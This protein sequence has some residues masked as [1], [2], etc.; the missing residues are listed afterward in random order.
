MQTFWTEAGGVPQ[1]INIIESAQNK[2]VCTPLPVTDAVM[3]A[4]T[5]R[6]ILAS[7]EYPN[8]MREWQKLTPADQ[9]W[10]KW[11]TKFLLAYTA[12]ELSDKARDA[13]GQPLGGQAIA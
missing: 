11:K 2:S 6:A 5:F 1:Y 10:D 12:K 9:T 7:G 4:I 3:Q 13:V 8:N